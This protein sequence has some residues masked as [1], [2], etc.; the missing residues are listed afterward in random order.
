MPI[1]GFPE[2]KNYHAGIYVISPDQYKPNKSIR[3]K[4][5]RSINLRKRL[6]DYNI[7]YN[8]GYYVYFCIIVNDNEDVNRTSQIKKDLIEITKELEEEINED[9]RQYNETYDTRKYKAEWFK[10]S[11]SKMEKEIKDIENNYDV[12]IISFI[13]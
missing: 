10:L 2:L 12:K 6:N 4:I 13:K 3:F 1:I 8:E 11:L 5:G 9:L 7:C